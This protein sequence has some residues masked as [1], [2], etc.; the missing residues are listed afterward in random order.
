MSDREAFE[1]FA[2]KMREIKSDAQAQAGDDW[3]IEVEAG[4]VVMIRIGANFTGYL[5]TAPP[6]SVNQNG[7]CKCSVSETTGWT[8]QAVCNVC[9]LVVDGVRLKPAV[10]QQLLEA[11]QRAESHL[12]A[13]MA[14]I[15]HK[16][17]R[18]QEHCWQQVLDIRAAIAA[19]QEQKL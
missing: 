3:V 14:H 13:M 18:F 9:N 19:A 7:C 1:K 16:P 4:Q 11:L 6:A 12:H 5:Y 10:N 17:Q 15:E 8:Q 2:A